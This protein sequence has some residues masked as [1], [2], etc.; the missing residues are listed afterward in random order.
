MHQQA[1]GVVST[2]HTPEHRSL[3]AYVCDAVTDVV[4]VRVTEAEVDVVVDRDV[5]TDT[6]TDRDVDTDT[7]D[8]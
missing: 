8:V 4:C 3:L 2:G 6:D 1:A 7:D 5:D